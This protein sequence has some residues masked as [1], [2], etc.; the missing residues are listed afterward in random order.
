M[1]VQ[2]SKKTF[3][4]DSL[5]LNDPSQDYFNYLPTPADPA[6]DHIHNPTPPPDH[7]YYL[8]LTTDPFYFLMILLLILRLILDLILFQVLLLILSCVDLSPSPPLDNPTC[9]S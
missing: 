7:F 6:Q 2:G 5:I 1:K 3:N 9:I 8:P 4:T